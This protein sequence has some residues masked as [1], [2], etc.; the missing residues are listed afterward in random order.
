MHI[1]NPG[2][3]PVGFVNDVPSNNHPNE[4]LVANCDGDVDA[5]VVH[6]DALDIFVDSDDSGHESPASGPRIQILEDIRL[7]FGLRTASDASDGES[8]EGSDIDS[9]LRMDEKM[10]DLKDQQRH[11]SSDRVAGSPPHSSIS[12]SDEPQPLC[13]YQQPANSQSALSIQVA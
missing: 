9:Y 7:P 2:E 13:S 11:R 8:S 10:V 4:P 5:L 1:I 3:P 12:H 6:Y